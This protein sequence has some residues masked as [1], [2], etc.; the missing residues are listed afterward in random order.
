[1]EWIL[2]FERKPMPRN[3]DYFIE[4]K[5]TCGITLKICVD[6]QFDWGDELAKDYVY[7]REI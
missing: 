3:E 7:W 4:V 1:M 5:D 6:A 2:F